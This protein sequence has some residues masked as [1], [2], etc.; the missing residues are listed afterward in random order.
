MKTRKFYPLL[1]II[2]SLALLSGCTS[3]LT[4]PPRTQINGS[5]TI[6]CTVKAQITPADKDAPEEFAFSGNAKR[7][8]SGFWEMELTSPESLSGLKLTVAGDSLTSSL[9]EL[10]YSSELGDIP[11]KSPVMTVFRCLDSAAVALDNGSNLEPA[12]GVQGSWSLTVGEFS[13]LFDGSGAPVAMTAAGLSVEFTEFAP[14]GD[15]SVT[16]GKS[17]Q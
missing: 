17:E 14:M 6:C 5:Y 3:P 11:K 2:L 15:E 13:L 12:S 9:G 4:P 8:G 7:L 16:L 10:T 1:C